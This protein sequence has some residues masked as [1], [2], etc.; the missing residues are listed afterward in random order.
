[1]MT[2]REAIRTAALAAASVAVPAPFVALETNSASAPPPLGRTSLPD[3]FTSCLAA[4]TVPFN[5]G[6]SFQRIDP[7][8]PAFKGPPSGAS[9]DDAD[10]EQVILPHTVKVESPTNSS[11][12]F[13]GVCWYVRPIP[14][15]SEWRDRRVSVVVDGAMQKTWV[16]INGKNVMT[17][18]GGYLPFVIDLTPY[19]ESGPEI[20]LAL[21]LDNNASAAFPPG[22]NRIDFCYWGGLYRTAR[23]VVT[24]ALHI[25]D[26]IEAGKVAGGGIFIRYEN[27]TNQSADVIAQANI[28]NDGPQAVQAGVEYSL[29]DEGGQ[30]VARAT[31]PDALIGA[32]QDL[33]FTGRLPM[34]QPLLWHPD[35]PHLYRL[36]TAVT[37][38]GAILD[39]QETSC[40]IRT[41]AYT[42]EGFF[43][44][45]E[46]LVLRGANRH[47]SFPWL[48]NAASDNLQYR[49]IRLLKEA[50]FNFVRLA[51]YPQSSSTMAACD[52]L[53]VMA[54]VCTPGWQ[55]FAN[56]DSFQ[57]N[58]HKNIREMVRWHRNH[59]SAILWE[60]SLNETPGHD[61]FY[62]GCCDVARAE[63]PGGQ[64]FTS[65]DSAQATNVRN[66]DL[67][68]TE[69]QGFY[70]RPLHP[71]TRIKMGLHREYG[72]YEFGGQASTT[73]VRRDAGEQKLLLQAWNFQWTHNQNLSFPYTIGDAIWAGLDNSST[74]DH[75]DAD[76]HGLGSWWGVLDLYRLPKFSYYFYQSQR[77][78]DLL[79]PFCDS[80]PMVRIAGYWTPRPSPTKVVVYSNGDE[81]EL[82]LNGR[83][84][85]RQQP[86]S[87]PDSAY[88]AYRIEADPMYWTRKLDTNTATAEGE[89]DAKGHGTAMFDGGNGLHLDH[90]PFTFMKVA[91]EPGEL[92][93]VAYRKGQPAARHSLRTPGP[94]ASL[95]LR[96]PDLGRGWVADGSDALFAYAD[97]V[98]GQ[99]EI[100]PDSSIPVR[101]KIEGPARFVNPAE[102]PAEAGIA[103]I[104]LQAGQT[105]GDILLTAEADNLKAGSITLSCRAA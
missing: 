71:D 81:V 64:L 11:H 57:E 84:V 79:L 42:D 22:S 17:H 27:V 35:H 12:Y 99:G 48:G 104:I 28:R 89:K 54:L 24:D 72:D 23:L 46:K 59:P 43:M 37:S 33:D 82:F 40:G 31:V 44:N 105:P 76:S 98:D 7:G 96:A 34:S 9:L 51:H 2:R 75:L 16:W 65:G 20:I 6:W 58:D 78:P 32:G 1:M 69:W 25:T 80:G 39:A 73:R 18:L 83:S 67:T 53:G 70:H 94:P 92:K 10:W 97:V 50:G 49:D 19:L 77:S 26:P 63:Y 100:V 36:L 60:V 101:F 5:Q 47:M 95:R 62:A 38:A 45:G 52:A 87:G 41:L 88:G 90:P 8:Q 56:T 86:D 21:C 91:Y 66:Y 102:T 30:V 29:I 14:V 93:A 68:Y 74:F 15:A 61:D 3:A 103:S 13:L 4:R 85:A 55:F